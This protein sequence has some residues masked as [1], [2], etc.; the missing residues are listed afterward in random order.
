MR[1][2]A[3]G[4]GKQIASMTQGEFLSLSFEFVDD[5]EALS[6][7]STGISILASNSRRF[8]VHVPNNA[9]IG[10]LAATVVSVIYQ[11]GA[12]MPNPAARTS[13]PQF[14]LVVSRIAKVL[15]SVATQ[16]FINI[17]PHKQGLMTDVV[18]SVKE[19]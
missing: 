11:H 1:L 8:F 5:L 19:N 10:R 18:Q 7:Q 2:E 12:H 13:Q 9:Q 3:P 4:S 15:V 6:P 16:F 17:L 14:E